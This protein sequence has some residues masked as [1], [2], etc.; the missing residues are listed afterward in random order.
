MIEP[1]VSIVIPVF[2]GANYL[3]D[4]I[5]SA[6][7]QT[8]KNCEVIVVND[9]SNDG[10]ETERIALSYGNR[11][12]YFC[13]PNGGVASALN[14]GI[15]EMRGEYFSWLSHDDYYLPNKI[16]HQVNAISSAGKGTFIYSSFM[17]HNMD[18]HSK[19]NVNFLNV[20]SEHDLNNSLFAILN[21]LICGCAT[22][23]PKTLFDSTGFFDESKKTTQ[24]ND[25]WFRMLRDKHIFY[26]DACDV[27][28]RQHSSQGSKSIPTYIN[29][30]DSLWISIEEQLKDYEKAAVYGTPLL[31]Y[32]KMCAYYRESPYKKVSIHYEQKLIET[33]KRYSEWKNSALTDEEKLTLV[34]L[35]NCEYYKE[36]LSNISNIQQP[37]KKESI[38]KRFKLAVAALGVKGAIKKAF[39]WLFNTL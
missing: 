12:R 39:R 9:G 37:I 35:D 11:I 27:V 15:K 36:Q 6:L 23:I 32:E 13:K 21:G 5:D 29:E 10:G 33:R 22:L 18:N 38:F 28:L 25:M 30:C 34:A 4:A 7:A 2:N 17:L 31:F 20:Y 26:C 16:M 19:V 24:D 1:F 14:V 8:Y 3:R